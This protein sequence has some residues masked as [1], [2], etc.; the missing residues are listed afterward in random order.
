[1]KTRS[2]IALAVLAAFA[3]A[4]VAHLRTRP[5]SHSSQAHAPGGGQQAAVESALVAPVLSVVAVD[6]VMNA[7]ERHTGLLAVEGVVGQVFVDRGAFTLIDVAEAQKCGG[8]HCAEVEMP[9][10]A[11]AGQ[12]DGVLPQ[13][14]ERVIVV[15][16]W[17]SQ[18]TAWRL[19]PDRITRAGEVVAR[20]R[21][22]DQN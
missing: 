19:I 22:G 8:V 15:G 16:E 3:G 11:G 7:P 9:V 12:L 4:G 18:G 13:S 14:T 10:V 6:T 2:V 17:R 20:R 5:A 1:M 21:R